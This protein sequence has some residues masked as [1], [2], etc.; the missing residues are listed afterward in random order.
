MIIANVATSVN[1]TI[2]PGMGGVG[3]VSPLIGVLSL[4]LADGNAF[5]GQFPIATVNARLVRPLV[6]NR[7]GD[8]DNQIVAHEW[9]HYI[10]NR[11]VGTASV[12]YTHLTL[13]TILRV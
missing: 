6:I 11:L 5:R 4:N 9:G 7:D 1:P 3:V 10:S 13:P 2:A 12:S 8:L